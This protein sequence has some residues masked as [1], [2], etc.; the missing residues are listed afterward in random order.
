M[1][2]GKRP[3]GVVNFCPRCGQPVPE[4]ARVCPNCGALQ[5]RGGERSQRQSGPPPGVPGAQQ[6]T[7]ATPSKPPS[8]DNVSFWPRVLAA[9][10]DGLVILVMQLPILAAL[11]FAGVIGFTPSDLEAM[12]TPEG[13]RF[14]NLMSIPLSLLEIAYYTVMNGTWGATLGKMALGMKIVRADGRPISYGIAFLR[15]VVKLILQQCTCSLMYLSVAVNAEHRGWHD[16]IV[17][18]RVIW[19]R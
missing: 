9:I 10:I 14:L 11:V 3:P 18:T 7:P 12:Q 4:G 16:Q 5:D 6:P 13:Q 17:G 15:I 19:T 2:D 1:S 8:F